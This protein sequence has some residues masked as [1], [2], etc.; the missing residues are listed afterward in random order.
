MSLI[1]RARNLNLLFNTLSLTIGVLIT[2]TLIAFPLAWLVCRT[3]IPGKKLITLASI[4]PLAIPGYVLAYAFLGLGGASG[5]VAQLFY[6]EIPR[7]SGYWG[8]LIV[9][10]LYTFPYLFLNLRSGLLGMDSNTEEAA[11]SLGL[12]TFRII[13]RVTLPQ[14][15]P[16]MLAGMLIIALYVIGDFGAVSL[17]RFETLSYALYLQYAAAYDRVYAAL[18]AI[19]LLM[20]TGVI[21]FMEYR[22]LKIFF[23]NGSGSG[24]LK[25]NRLSMLGKLKI[26]AL[27]FAG[28]IFILSVLLPLFSI[29]FWMLNGVDARIWTQLWSALLASVS[30][31]APAAVFA[32]LLAVPLAYIS[33]RFPSFITDFLQRI[34]YLGYATPP[35]ALALAYLFFSLLVMPGLYQSLILLIFCYAIHFLAESLSPVRSAMYSISPKLEE[36]ARSL[37]YGRFKAFLYTTLPLLYQGILAGFIFVF[38]SAMKEL[39]ITFLLSPI[40]FET[41][42]LNVWSYAAEAMF[43]EAAP[44]ALSILLF[45]G[46]F[47]GLLFARVWK[48]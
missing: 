1:W 11:R 38:L 42:A 28:S 6:F 34:A 18:I 2:T 15:R 23:F 36:A 8:S 44:F 47:V 43:A 32:V 17:M 39:P 19:M 37:G 41:L 40:G 46:F 7:L 26:P 29:S 22:L 14:L 45:S 5:S 4:V 20:L 21:I 33:L 30:A 25:H 31:S 35:L 24:S 10:S 48:P 27:M 9:I 12:N 13:W 16:S 3:D